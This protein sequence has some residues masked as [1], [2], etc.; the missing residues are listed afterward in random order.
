M[1]AQHRCLPHLAGAM[2]IV[3]IVASALAITPAWAAK[4]RSKP[5]PVA[6]GT[7]DGGTTSEG[8]PLVLKL[9]S[10]RRRI[11]SAVLQVDLTC[12]GGSKFTYYGRATFK[13]IEP[14]SPDPETTVFAPNTLSPTGAISEVGSGLELTPGVVI[15]F[16]GKLTGRVRGNSAGGALTARVV[17]GDPKTGDPITSCQASALRWTATSAPRRVFAG[18]TSQGLPVVVEESATATVV[19]H[20]LIGWM[21][22]CGADGSL[23]VGDDVPALTLDA[24]GVFDRTLP[25][26]L[27][28]GSQSIHVQEA[29]H[30]QLSATQATGT[31][32]VTL[33]LSDSS[34]APMASCDTGQVHFTAHTSAH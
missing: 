11:V 9:G 7:V 8:N 5:K 6:T 3:L 29:V 2:L 17:F 26:D 13:A 14:T 12:A 1:S 10:D 21:A 4:S 23:T 28:S 16:T 27:T 33:A 20:L 19:D 31:V 30:G 22:T 18:Q 34:G 15:T 24:T 32:D 25:V